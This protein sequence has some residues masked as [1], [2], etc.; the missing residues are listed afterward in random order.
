[1][2]IF[3]GG[4]FTNNLVHAAF[5]GSSD[6]GLFCVASDGNYYRLLQPFFVQILPY[7]FSCLIT[8]HNRHIT[9]H[10]YQVVLARSRLV[11]YNAVFNCV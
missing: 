6:V 9:V 1:M 4:R 2:E 3:C 5:D 10:Q 11:F 7:L 8:I